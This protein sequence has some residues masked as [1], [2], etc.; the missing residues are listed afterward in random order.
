MCIYIYIYTHTHY[1]LPDENSLPAPLAGQH[2]TF[3]NSEIIL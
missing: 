1:Q 2:P 3:V